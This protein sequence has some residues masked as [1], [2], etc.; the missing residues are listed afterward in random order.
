MC[1]EKCKT[2]NHIDPCTM[3]L[4]SDAFLWELLNETPGEIYDVDEEEKFNVESYINGN[5]DY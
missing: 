5:T 3:A 1:P 4:E 2:L